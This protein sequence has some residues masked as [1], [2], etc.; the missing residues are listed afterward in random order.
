MPISKLLCCG[1][2]LALVGANPSERSEPVEGAQQQVKPVELPKVA[3]D[4]DLRYLE[5]YFDDYTLIYLISPPKDGEEGSG[6]L[7]GTLKVDSLTGEMRPWSMQEQAEY[8]RRQ[9]PDEG[10]GGVSATGGSV[11]C[12]SN[13][14]YGV[15]CTAIIGNW[16]CTYCTC[17]D[18]GGKRCSRSF[19]DCEKIPS[20]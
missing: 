3:G 11:S 12:A 16:L 6:T 2:A 8:M 18:Q 17:C 1:A 20:E 7:Q 5:A 10:F 13:G 14:C 4:N 19:F 15:C 9:H